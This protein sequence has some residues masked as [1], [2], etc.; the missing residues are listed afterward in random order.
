[1]TNEADV[2]KEELVRR[3]NAKGLAHKVPV[4]SGGSAGVER[5]LDT[6]IH[7]RNPNPKRVHDYDRLP[8]HS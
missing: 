5:F 4:A 1:M 6:P 2:L 8:P 7:R 3:E